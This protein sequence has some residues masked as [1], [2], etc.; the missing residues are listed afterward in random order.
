MRGIIDCAM[1]EAWCWTGCIDGTPHARLMIEY[2]GIAKRL[3]IAPTEDHQLLAYWIEHR[4]MIVARWWFSIR[5]DKLRP[6]TMCDGGVRRCRGQAGC[7]WGHWCMAGR[8]RRRGWRELQC[9]GQAC[10]AQGDWWRFGL[11]QR[12]RSASRQRYVL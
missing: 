8:Q 9:R 5:R 3:S 7:A 2:P 6:A 12:W 11:G 10:S 1:P 4:G